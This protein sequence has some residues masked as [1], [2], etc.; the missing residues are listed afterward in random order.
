MENILG[1][2]IE[3]LPVIPQENQ[4]LCSEC[5]GIG[6]L[7]TDKQTLSSC[8]KCSHGLIDVC[9][10]CKTPYKKRYSHTC[11]Q[12]ECVKKRQLELAAEDAEKELLRFKKA[13]KVMLKD[14][15][16][17]SVQMMYSSF[18]GY[19]EGFFSEVEELEDYLEDQ[20][21]DY[22]DEN[23]EDSVKMPSYVWATK[24]T[25]ISIDAED[26]IENACSDLH[27][28]AYERVENIAELQEF[29]DSWCE[30]QIGTDS[31]DIDYSLAI[32]LD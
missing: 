12:P 31:Y 13:K 29:L 6:W 16:Q 25:R 21:E 17:E 30:K 14:A 8:P 7:L 1:K 3:L 15:P 2:K 18:Y 22:E 4:I 9:P 24:V 32:L 10:T 23:P 27:E 11:E 19:N 20:K 5:G 26:V 28:E